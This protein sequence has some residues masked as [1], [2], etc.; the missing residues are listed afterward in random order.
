MSCDVTSSSTK[1]WPTAWLLSGHTP[2]DCSELVARAWHCHSSHAGAE[3]LEL[4]PIQAASRDEGLQAS[5]SDSE[6]R[7]LKVAGRTAAVFVELK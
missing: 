7:L 2:H 6:R 3:R 5:G 1:Q 4:H